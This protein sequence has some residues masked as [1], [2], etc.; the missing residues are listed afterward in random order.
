M[1]S[2]TVL[3]AQL[4]KNEDKLVEC[5]LVILEEIHCVVGPAFADRC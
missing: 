4:L 3:T 1:P 5:N 2:E